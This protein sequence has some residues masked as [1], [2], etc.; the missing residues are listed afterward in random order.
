MA[1]GEDAEGKEVKAINI[2]KEMPSILENP[3]RVV[4]DK[5]RLLMLYIISQEGIKETD[6][7]RLLELA[8][9]KSETEIVNLRYLGISLSAPQ[10]KT[11]QKIEK[12]KKKKNEN[13]DAPPFQL[14]RYVPLLKET[15]E[16][17]IDGNLSDTIFPFTKEGGKGSEKTKEEEAP[18]SVRKGS[19]PRWA[20]KSNK[21]SKKD[22]KEKEKQGGR[23]VVF[24]IGGMT[25]SEMRTVYELTAKHNRDITIGSNFI[26]TPEKFIGELKTLRKEEANAL[27]M[28]DDDVEE[29]E[30]VVKPKSPKS[31]KAVKEENKEE[32]KRGKKEKKTKK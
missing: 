12:S 23:I 14:S 7:K 31:P 25:Y 4:E 5:I 10:K 13:L 9:L 32:K 16:S 29:E 15:I 26:L 20:E 17:L 30:P 2:L 27:K 1:T 8:N 19:Q 21:K 11:K 3:N 18:T 24:Y 22:K 6:R 28:D